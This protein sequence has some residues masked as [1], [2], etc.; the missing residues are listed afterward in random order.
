MSLA[1]T[2]WKRGW[3]LCIELSIVWNEEKVYIKLV[4]FETISS[5]KNSCKKIASECLKE[6]ISSE[7]A[8]KSI[9]TQFKKQFKN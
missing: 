3:Y 5:R 4:L 1:R 2:K 8:L 9:K 7:K 6:I